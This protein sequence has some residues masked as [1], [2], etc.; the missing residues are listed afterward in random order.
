MRRPHLD[1]MGLPDHRTRAAPNYLYAIE[2][3]DLT[4]KIGTTWNPRAR[5][6]TVENKLGKKAARV[7]A[8]PV[9]R[10]YR[11]RAEKMALLRARSMSVQRRECTEL[12][13]GLKFGEAVNLLRQM[14]PRAE[15]AAA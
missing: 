5:V 15:K 9:H 1:A 11:H 8:V 7:V 10:G 3:T 12:F 6:V 13:A 2:F 4:V 14:A